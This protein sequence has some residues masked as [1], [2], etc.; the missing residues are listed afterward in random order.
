MASVFFD[1]TK[2]TARTFWDDP[3]EVT[4]LAHSVLCAFAEV[5]TDFGGHVLGLRGDGLYAGFG[6]VVSAEVCVAVA[7]IA[8]ATAIDAIQNDLNPKL[9]LRKISPIQARAGADFGRTSFI[10][11]GSAEASEVN[12]IGFAPN[13]AAKCEKAAASWEVVV[14]ETFASY[15]V[16][17]A[18]LE[19]HPGSPKRYTRVDETKSYGFS[20]YRWAKSLKW[21]DSTID[22]IR[23]LPLENLVM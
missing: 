6:P 17:K 4:M 2:F 23:G 13:F 18:L 15:I 21:V 14:G 10:R 3:E 22:E 9:A 1:L 8:C 7:A 5:V 11:S 16:D 12:V 20:K 19:T